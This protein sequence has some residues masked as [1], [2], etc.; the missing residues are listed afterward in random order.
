[1]PETAVTAE[2]AAT[3]AWAET[4]KWAWPVAPQPLVWQV[5]TA[6]RAVAERPGLP[7]ATAVRSLSPWM[8]PASSRLPSVLTAQLAPTAISAAVDMVGMAPKEGPAARARQACQAPMG[9]RLEPTVP[10]VPMLAMAGTVVQGGTA[11]RPGLTG[12]APCEPL[13][14]RVVLAARAAQPETADAA[15]MAPPQ[16]PGTAEAADAAALLAN[17]AKAAWAAQLA[18]SA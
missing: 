17:L 9:L 12:M 18:A 1:M 7:A 8:G 11:A 5:V 6:G 13:T 4:A 14:E 10:T 16:P 15:E 2:T 3:A